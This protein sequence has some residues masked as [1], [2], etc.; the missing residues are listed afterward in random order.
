MVAADGVSGVEGQGE[1]PMGS[2]VGT[3]F[4]SQEAVR[5]S[6]GKSRRGK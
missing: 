3:F 6:S 4:V 2:W 1:G 5:R